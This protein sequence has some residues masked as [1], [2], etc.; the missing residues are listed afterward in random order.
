MNISH[1]L[2]IV[3]VGGVW[4]GLGELCGIYI[5]SI[6]SR[7]GIWMTGLVVAGWSHIVCIGAD[8]GI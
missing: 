3:V 2:I 5:Y 1:G 8:I 7:S 6:N 4:W